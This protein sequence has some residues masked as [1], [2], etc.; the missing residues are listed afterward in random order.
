MS[1]HDAGQVNE[2]GHVTRAGRREAN[3]RVLNERIAESQAQIAV[4]LQA[5]LTILCECANPECNESIEVTQDMFAVLR[6][7]TTR[8]IVVEG[9]VLHDIED[10]V[11]RGDGWIIV[12]KRGAAAQEARRI[13]E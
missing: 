11:E 5:P 12:E 13:L 3:L 10:V 7:E 9:H 1:E 6:D 8:F 2:H 4:A